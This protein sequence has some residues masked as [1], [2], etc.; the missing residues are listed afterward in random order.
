MHFQEAETDQFQRTE[1]EPPARKRHMLGKIE[2]FLDWIATNRVAN[3]RLS[4]LTSLLSVCAV[5][6]GV[7]QYYAT[8]TERELQTDV[9]V[10]SDLAQNYDPKNAIN[11][12]AAHDVSMNSIQ[13][14]K[15]DLSGVDIPWAN[16]SY[17][18]IE[19]SNFSNGNLTGVEFAGSTLYGDDF[20]FA[21][22]A[23][24]DL[25]S[26]NLNQKVHNDNF[27]GAILPDNADLAALAAIA[28]VGLDTAHN[29]IWPVLD[30]ATLT[31]WPVDSAG[32][33]QMC[34]PPKLAQ[35]TCVSFWCQAGFAAKFMFEIRHLYEVT[36]NPY[37]REL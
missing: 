29:P 25:N 37:L 1:T 17:A 5:M 36:I 2:T 26:L 10:W 34:D 21:D 22:L 27:S 14:F 13:L 7:Y 4:T 33:P 16:L 23:R 3:Q 35:A 31:G 19:D 18:D 12:L 9:P 32:K 24:A 20:S 30:G 15:E 11:L 8:S 6:A 28:C